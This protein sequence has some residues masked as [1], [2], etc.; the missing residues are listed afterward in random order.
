M[1]SVHIGA[2]QAASVLALVAA[3]WL[4][5]GVL[6]GVW[7]A[8]CR[9]CPAVLATVAPRSVRCLVAAAC[10]LVV[11]SGAAVPSFAADAGAGAVGAS[12]GLEPGA[13]ALEGL[14]LPDR[15]RSSPPS[16]S[17]TE[18]S[19]G[20]RAQRNGR[21]VVVQA[22]DSLWSVTEA[23]LGRPDAAVV[24]RVWPMLYAANRRQIGPDPDLIRPGMALR[25]PE[26]LST[27]TPPRAPDT[28]APTPGPHPRS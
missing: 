10:G 27:P 1:T 4:G 25:L 9:A 21:R 3:S 28:R 8:T 6:A 19:P 15:Q 16:S 20:R 12:A 2:E 17:E 5:L 14:G 18:M 22:G 26:H 11:G 13:T 23:V 7:E 24:S